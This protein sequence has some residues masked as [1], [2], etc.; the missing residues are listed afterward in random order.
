MF[1]CID[2][3]LAINIVLV[4]FIVISVTF[5]ANANDSK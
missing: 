5:K 3:L 4:M 1:C 2:T